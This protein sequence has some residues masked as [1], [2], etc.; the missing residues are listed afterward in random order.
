MRER[1]RLASYDV[2]LY[3]P[4]DTPEEQLDDVVDLINTLDLR[5]KLEELVVY[6]VRTRRLLAPLS[7]EVDE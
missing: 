7:V 5:S 1:Q 2:T 4:R 6:Y 3:V